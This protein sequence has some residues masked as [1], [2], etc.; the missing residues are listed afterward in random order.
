RAEE[1]SRAGDPMRGGRGPGGGCPPPGLC[2]TDSALLTQLCRLGIGVWAPLT[3]LGQCAEKFW[4][5]EHL[6]GLEARLMPCSPLYDHFQGLLVFLLRPPRR[7]I[8]LHLA[9]SGGNSRWEKTAH[10]VHGKDGGPCRY[11]L[12]QGVGV[13][14]FM[15]VGG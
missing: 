14:D 2:E 4:R 8:P 12:V 5:Q 3:R 10:C 15:P 13:Y 6:H 9:C 7:L 11:M 1:Q